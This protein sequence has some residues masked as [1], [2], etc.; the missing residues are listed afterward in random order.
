MYRDKDR[1]GQDPAK[2]LRSA[3]ATFNSPMKWHEPALVFTCSWSDFFIA[4]ADQW[5]AD[6]FKIM[7]ATPHLTYQVLTKRADRIHE[8][9]PMWGLPENVWLGVSIESQEQASRADYLVDLDCKTFASFEPLI[10]PIK[11]TKAMDELDWIIIGGESGNDKGPYR[12]R[13][14]ELGWAEYL[15]AT[16]QRKGIPVFMKQ[17]G[18]H[19]AKAQEYS[20]RHGGD[21]NE[22]PEF[23]KVR[24]FP[25]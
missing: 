14:M 18:T 6:A 23:F 16:A 3:P 1:Y 12:Y 4:E 11:W 10:G 15:I 13:P 24:Q 20:D 8:C 21:L 5:R 9:L 25:K 19:I 17:M 7:Q 2:V 22:W